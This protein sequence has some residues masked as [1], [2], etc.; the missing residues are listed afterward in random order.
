MQ[1]SEYATMIY[2]PLC[3]FISKIIHPHGNGLFIGLFLKGKEAKV[4]KFPETQQI[5]FPPFS[6]LHLIGYFICF[7]VITTIT[8]QYRHEASR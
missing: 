5:S 1:Q 4:K 6:C 2:F 3:S 7:V 8:V